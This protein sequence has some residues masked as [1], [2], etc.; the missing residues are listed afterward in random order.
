MSATCSSLTGHVGAPHDPALRRDRVTVTGPPGDSRLC[1]RVSEN[2]FRE[3][4]GPRRPAPR[5]VLS[6]FFRCFVFGIG[7][8]C[9]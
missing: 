9:E 2:P 1:D 7:V 5:R 3:G 6:P 4:V 8:C